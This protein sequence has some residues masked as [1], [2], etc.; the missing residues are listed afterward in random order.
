MR[1]SQCLSTY[2]VHVYVLSNPDPLSQGDYGSEARVHTHSV[3]THTMLPHLPHQNMITHR[4]AVIA[5]VSQTAGG[6]VYVPTV[7]MYI[8]VY[9]CTCRSMCTHV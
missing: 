9:T 2:M 6:T 5:G 8:H 4:T 1:I 3:Y 7:Y